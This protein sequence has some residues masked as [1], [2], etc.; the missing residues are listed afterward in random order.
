MLALKSAPS[1]ITIVNIFIESLEKR[2]NRVIHLKGCMFFFVLFIIS[3]FCYF[4]FKKI[5]A[6]IILYVNGG[7]V[8][9]IYVCFLYLVGASPLTLDSMM[10]ACI[11]LLRGFIFYQIF[12]FLRW[13]LE[14]IR[15]PHAQVY[16][17]ITISYDIC[18]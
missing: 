11:A 6:S 14:Q 17:L 18:V 2:G 13:E 9:N 3:I 1:I 8:V 7:S 15:D 4:Q 10:A 12:D 5:F 16:L